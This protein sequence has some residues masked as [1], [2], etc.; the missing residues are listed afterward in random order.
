MAIYIDGARAANA[1]V[2]DVGT[3]DM[4]M[5]LQPEGI[6][7]LGQEADRPSGDFDEYQA[8]NGVIDE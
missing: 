3:C 7:H 5:P 2:C 4:G 8:L 1:T 6:I